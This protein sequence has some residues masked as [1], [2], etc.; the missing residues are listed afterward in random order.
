[1]KGLK[2]LNVGEKLVF[3]FYISPLLSGLPSPRKMM[4]DLGR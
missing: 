3:Y 1:M 2:R 4:E